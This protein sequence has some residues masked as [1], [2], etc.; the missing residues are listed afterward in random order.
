VACMN[1]GV[2][3]DWAAGQVKEKGVLVDVDGKSLAW[4]L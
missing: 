3:V 4:V 1:A 2:K